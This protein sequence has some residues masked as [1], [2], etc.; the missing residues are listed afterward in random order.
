MICAGEL[1][2]SAST[3]STVAASAEE[4]RAALAHTH[5]FRTPP[6]KIRKTH[7]TGPE[8]PSRE[9]TELAG[10]RRA[11][12]VK[13]ETKMA[14]GTVKCQPAQPVAPASQP[15]TTFAQPV[16]LP[17]NQITQ[18]QPA[19][20]PAHTAKRPK[21]TAAKSSAAPKHDTSDTSTAPAI[22]K[23]EPHEGVKTPT[24]P[25]PLSAVRERH[26]AAAAVENLRRPDST[27]QL[28][29]TATPTPSAGDVR[30]CRDPLEAH[31]NGLGGPA[32]LAHDDDTADP[33]TDQ[34]DEPEHDEPAHESKREE[35][36]DPAPEPP[37]KKT[38]RPKTAQEKANHARFMRFTRHIQ[39]H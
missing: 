30:E 38:R 17:S 31:I 27:Q 16:T 4:L 21:I 5:G 23:S 24:T 2:R 10:G 7:S 35:P 15:E 26:V 19:P 32:T 33:G 36:V 28:N 39:S 1:N 9:K 8:E 3:A 6:S 20:E 25:G 37:A 13:K 12:M 22:A 34:V 29:Q 18:T 11:A 14:R